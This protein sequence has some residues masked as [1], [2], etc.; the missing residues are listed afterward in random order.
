MISQSGWTTSTCYVDSMFQ[1]GDGTAFFRLKVRVGNV[2]SGWSPIVRYPSNGWEIARNSRGRE[3][4]F[5]KYSLPKVFKMY[6]NYPNPFNMTTNITYDLPKEGQV[7]VEIWNILGM[8]IAILENRSRKAGSYTVLW[9]GKNMNG[10]DVGT[11]VY[12]YTIRV[13][14]S[15]QILFQKTSKL[16]LLK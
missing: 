6:Q 10:Q 4:F 5:K 11:G 7:R 3:A 9:N 8:K 15:G 1:S 2:E 16:L 14:N 12:F 13:S